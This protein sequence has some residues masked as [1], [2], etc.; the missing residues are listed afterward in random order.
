[1]ESTSNKPEHFFL[2]I[3]AIFFFSI[4]V[5][6][7]NCIDFTIPKPG[8]IIN[9]PYC[10]LAVEPLC[11]NIKSIEFRARY[12]ASKTDT[13]TVVTIGEISRPPYKQIWDI[14]DIP[15][16]LFTGVSFLA[17]AI[18][19]NGETT[20]VR[21]EGVFFAHQ[22]TDCPLVKF[23]YEY[24]GTKEL[25][26]LKDTLVINSPRSTVTLLTSIYW[27]EKDIT[28]LAEVRDPLFYANMSK[29]ALSNMGIE[30]L[31]DPDQSRKPFPNKDVFI[32]VVPLSG[33]PYK[34]VYK[35]V[36]DETGSFKLIPQSMPYDYTYSV[37]KE[38]FKGFKIYFPIPKQVFSDKIPKEIAFNIIFKL[39]NEKNDII[40]V[41]WIKG[42]LY[43]TYSPYV[44][45]TVRFLPKPFIKNKILL[46]CLF[47]VCGLLITLLIYKVASF[48][49]KPR[50]LNNFEKSEA[51][52]Q[53]FVRIKETIEKRVTNKGFTLEIAAR[54][55]KMNP[56][57]LNKMIRKFTSMSFQNYLMYSRTEIA[58]ERLRSSH[59]SEASIADACG[60][61]D[62]N[63]LEKFFTKFHKTTL[64][65]F[66]NEHQ[67][68]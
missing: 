14:K 39:L 59:S 63:E 25:E 54:D 13:G 4:V 65:K 20:G 18:L 19:K 12:F 8:T 31:I 36:Y 27:N 52:Q 41:P 28:V 61:Q 46:G 21:R 24:S 3:T 44:W 62:A 33:K 26:L 66:R 42:S 53:L 34:I 9:T 68:A 49:H 56:K 57:R 29:D 58:K 7:E 11:D 15:N 16:Q 32:F 5:S 6:A 38:D 47:F 45:G 67:V 50:A 35:T 17:E 64:Y 2:F 10:T 22:K 51:E 37:T 43:E 60:F 55:L 30:I 40:K 23:N 48:F 1:V